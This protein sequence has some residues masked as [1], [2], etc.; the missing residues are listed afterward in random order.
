[1]V[2]REMQTDMLLMP[3]LFYS[4]KG[5]NASTAKSNFSFTS[6]CGTVRYYP[7]SIRAGSNDKG[8]KTSREMAQLSSHWPVYYEDAQGSPLGLLQSETLW[9]Q[10]S[11][12]SKVAPAGRAT[13]HQGFLFGQSSLAS[14]VL[15]VC[16][17]AGC[18]MQRIGLAT[19]APLNCCQAPWSPTIRAAINELNLGKGSSGGRAFFYWLSCFDCFFFFFPPP[20]FLPSTDYSLGFQSSL[21]L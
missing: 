6:N 14:Q 4:F 1:M 19:L 10:C 9:G 16:Q 15:G 2:Y 20:F 3:K 21:C 12:W 5:P 11:E 13:V 17:N 8:P 7:N 18:K